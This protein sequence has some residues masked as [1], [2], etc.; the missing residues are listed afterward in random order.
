MNPMSQNTRRDVYVYKQPVSTNPFDQF[1]DEWSVGLCSCCE[2]VRQC[3][4]TIIPMNWNLF[5]CFL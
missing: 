5:G 2:D 4:M 3:E 1:T